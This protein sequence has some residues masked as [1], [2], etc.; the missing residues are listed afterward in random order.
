MPSHVMF[1]EKSSVS[2]CIAIYVLNHI[3][4]IAPF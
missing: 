4:D 3:H 2:H 1:S